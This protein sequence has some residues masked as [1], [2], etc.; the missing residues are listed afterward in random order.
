VELLKYISCRCSGITR[1][2]SVFRAILILAHISCLIGS[3]SY[4]DS[5]V[6]VNCHNLVPTVKHINIFFWSFGIYNLWCK[7]NFTGFE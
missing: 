5:H 6:W 4:R 1:G 7:V 3:C 2:L